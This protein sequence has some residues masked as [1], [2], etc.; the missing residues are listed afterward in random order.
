MRLIII[1]NK[2]EK[3]K[4]HVT[5]FTGRA[6][7]TGEIYAGCSSL[8][9]G[10]RRLPQAIGIG[11]NSR[12]IYKQPAGNPIRLFRRYMHK[13]TNV[14]SKER[15]A[16][17]QLLDLIGS[18]IYLSDLRV[19]HHPLYVILFHKAVSTEHLHSLGCHMHSGI[20]AD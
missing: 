17:Y 6:G 2:K 9:E 15:S 5:I 1:L 7:A 4:P 10:R 11:C 20:G 14:L 12:N 19:S 16:D 3:V 18:L 8:R 13:L